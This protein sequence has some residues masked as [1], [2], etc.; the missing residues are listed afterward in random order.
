MDVRRI[1]SG[2]WLSI[3][4]LTA[5]AVLSGCMGQRPAVGAR[6]ERSFMESKAA[7]AG[8]RA[9]SAYEAGDYRKS[10]SYSMESLRINRSIDNRPGELLDLINIGRIL[11]SAGDYERARLYISDAVRLALSSGDSGRLSEAYATQAKADLLSGSVSSAIDSIEEA[12][13]I[14]EKLG[15]ISGERLNIKGMIYLREEMLPEASEAFEEALKANRSDGNGIE[16]ANSIRALAK[17]RWK[18]R[19]GREALIL[20][21]DAY[22]I[23]KGGG[24]SGKI[25]LD[26]LGMADIYFGDN[27]FK[28]AAFL[29][30][31]SY[32]VS[33]NAGDRA[34]ALKSLEM[35]I[36]SYRALA[37][38][39]KVIYYT[40]MR[41][42]LR[43]ESVGGE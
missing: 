26:L 11:I 38:E 32:I 20:Y 40:R 41:Q 6:P 19:K 34:G 37:D 31:R 39:A 8:R 21:R 9:V 14:D 42:G 10:L 17:I 28:E 22:E 5:L 3:L 24:D 36:E 4:S 16:T 30:E 25:A 1:V 29:Y 43:G 35:V 2:R 33:L 15:R 12:L 13:S 7:E 27:D 18:E 23:D